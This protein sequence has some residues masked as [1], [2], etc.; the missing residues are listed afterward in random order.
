MEGQMEW[1]KYRGKREGWEEVKKDVKGTAK[2]EDRKSE[3][4]LVAREYERKQMRM[5]RRK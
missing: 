5:K 3:R 4:S 1:R 2:D